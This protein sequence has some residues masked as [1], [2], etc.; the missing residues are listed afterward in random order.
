MT[1][2][3]APDE[4]G[5]AGLAR[6]VG[7]TIRTLREK[8]Q[9][10]TRELGRRAGISQAFLSQIERGVSAPS[11][12]TLY[13]LAEALGVVPGALLPSPAAGKVTVVRS[14]EGEV[15]PVADRPDSAVGR[16]LLMQP[17]A[18]LEV[19]EYRLE[20]GQY[21]DDW[22]E[23]PGE[24]ALYMLAGRLA[25]EIEGAGEYRLGPGDFMAHPGELRN[26]WSLVDD[27]GAHFVHTVAH[28]R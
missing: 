14:G 26:R 25:V 27:G 24:T 18:A 9:L 10:S 16:S 7:T 2:D 28:Q 5:D 12:F 3:K 4:L 6:A 1:D 11:M 20:P 17:G 21:A 22:W 23:F 19:T 15:L 8:S 13:R